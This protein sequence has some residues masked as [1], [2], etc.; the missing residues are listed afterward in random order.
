MH[1]SIVA[2]LSVCFIATVVKMPSNLPTAMITK[3]VLLLKDF[4]P[5]LSGRF[6]ILHRYIEPISNSES[7]NLFNNYLLWFLFP[8]AN[9]EKKSCFGPFYKQFLFFFNCSNWDKNS[10]TNLW[11]HLMNSLIFETSFCM[12]I[13]GNSIF[14]YP[15][16]YLQT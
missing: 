11:K 13:Y 10:V 3:L 15:Y 2:K 9:W 8:P 7:M 5:H 12:S 4:D 14:L 1:P 16:I 6:H